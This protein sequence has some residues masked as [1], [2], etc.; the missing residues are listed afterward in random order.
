MIFF[1]ACVAAFLYHRGSPFPYIHLPN[2]SQDATSSISLAFQAN[3]RRSFRHF[4][5]KN[6]LLFYH[7]SSS[8]SFVSLRLFTSTILTLT[9]LTHTHF[10]TL[11][12]THHCA[13]QQGVDGR[14][15]CTGRFVSAF[16]SLLLFVAAPPVRVP[17]ISVLHE[18]RTA[19]GG[20]ARLPPSSTQFFF[21]P[22]GESQTT[23]HST[24]PVCLCVCACASVQTLAGLRCVL[25]SHCSVLG[26]CGLVSVCSW[27]YS[28]SSTSP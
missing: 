9:T 8:P 2:T 20:L 11:T 1:L 21:F 28:S 17:F 23:S 3:Q 15:L 7:I 24:H 16:L 13:H 27:K 5:L 14:R 4:F 6:T 26:R 22:E 10:L 19:F 12:Q 25:F 18:R